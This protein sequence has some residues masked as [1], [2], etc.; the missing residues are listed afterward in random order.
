[1][2]KIENLY[3]NFGKTKAVEGISFQVKKGEVFGL[4]GPNGAGKSTTISIISTLIPPT[5]GEILFEGNSIL[6][7]PKNIRQ[8]LGLV[9][10]DLAL[11]MI[12]F[13][14]FFSSYTMVF[15]I[16]TLLNDKQYKS[17]E[18]M[19]ISPLSMTS[20]LGGTMLVS[21]LVGLVQIGILIIGGKYL[22]AVDWGRS[23]A[24]IGMVAAAYVFTITS[25]GLMISS[26]VKT[27]AQLS[28]VAPVVL[29]STAMVGGS[30]WPL[31]IVNNKILLFLAELTPHKWTI[32]GMESIAAKGMGFEAAITPTIVLF[33]MGIIYFTIGVKTIKD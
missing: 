16:G 13:T 5:E 21:F 2:L 25:M 12:G 28:A 30:M 10:Q 26:L 4:L 15:S 11:S 19:I 33:L 31:E 29:T 17:W 32:Q 14:V 20:I 27:Q 23:M 9:P 1:M 8:K 6:S 22:L 7:N 18:R 3:K 24:G